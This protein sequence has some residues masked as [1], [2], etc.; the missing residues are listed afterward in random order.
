MLLEIVSLAEWLS[1]C[2]GQFLQQ[3]VNEAW[4]KKLEKK[5][6]I[7]MLNLIIELALQCPNY[8]SDREGE[9]SRALFPKQ[10]N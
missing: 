10:L 9:K 8:V 1:F 5:I 4:K 7:F 2:W 6:S 3:Y